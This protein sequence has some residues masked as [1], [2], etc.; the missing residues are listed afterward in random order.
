MSWRSLGGLEGPWPRRSYLCAACKTCAVRGKS[1]R[2][3][4]T[5]NQCGWW[6][7]QDCWIPGPW[8]RSSSPP[9]AHL[10]SISPRRQGVES[11]LWGMG[12]LHFAAPVGS[13][14]YFLLVLR[15][16]AAQRWNLPGLLQYY[17]LLSDV[18]ALPKPDSALWGVR[19]PLSGF[20]LASLEK[21]AAARLPEHCWWLLLIE[22]VPCNSFVG[23][24]L[25]VAYDTTRID[26]HRRHQLMMLKNQQW[27][28]WLTRA[29]NDTCTIQKERT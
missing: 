21:S 20:A 8:E 5:G 6:D 16:L 11:R 17:C 12:C 18:A 29:H 13:G 1:W 7:R 24:V 15:G 3:Q 25:A 22:W 4:W 14:R 9:F 27:A 19:R 2:R 10:S 26:S 28:T 23:G